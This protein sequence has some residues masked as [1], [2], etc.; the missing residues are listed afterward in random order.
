MMGRVSSETIDK[1][2]AFFLS[3]PDEAK[4]KCALCNETLTHIVKQAE[5]QT[6]A[7]TATVV[8]VLAD[9]INENA[10]PADKMSDGALRQRVLLNDGSICR[11]PTNRAETT[12]TPINKDDQEYSSD[13]KNIHCDPENIVKTVDNL[14]RQFKTQKK[15]FD[16][17]AESTG[18]NRATLTGRYWR[19]KKKEKQQDEAG[20]VIS[21]QFISCQ[22]E[23][24]SVDTPEK[25]NETVLT[26]KEIE[27]MKLFNKFLSNVKKAKESKWNYVRYEIICRCVADLNN[28]I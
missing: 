4:S 17:L 27:F 8:K 11:N 10:A 16:N 15:A 21:E 7:G 14:T 25:N 1:I 9:H 19:A 20:R 28:Q 26:D 18:I 5:V 22:S 2:N 3:L 13:E 12:E 24:N 23:D 6:G